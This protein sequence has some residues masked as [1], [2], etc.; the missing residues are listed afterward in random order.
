[1]FE[2][3]F[4]IWQNV[5]AKKKKGDISKLFTFRFSKENF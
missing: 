5:S 3:S 1:M 4:Q 2:K